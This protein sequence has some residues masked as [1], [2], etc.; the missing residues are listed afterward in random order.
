MDWLNPIQVT[1]DLN[2][3]YDTARDATRAMDE[4]VWAVDPQ[5]DTIGS[6]ATYLEN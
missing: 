2:Q 6:L 4:I 3:I 5:H 1:D